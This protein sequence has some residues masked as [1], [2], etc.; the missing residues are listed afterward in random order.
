[1]TKVPRFIVKGGKYK[2][3][4]DKIDELARCVEERTPLESKNNK[5]TT[6]PNGFTYDANPGAGNNTS[7]VVP[8]WG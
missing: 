8:R 2:H 7:N 3:L 5:L 6:R 4:I 1:M